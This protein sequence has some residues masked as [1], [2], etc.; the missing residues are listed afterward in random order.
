MKTKEMTYVALFAAI[1]IVLGFLPPIVLPFTPVPITAQTL[2]VMLAGVVLGARL[3]G[4]SMIVF[5]LII[6][7][8]VP[9]LAGG[10]GG[11]SAFVGPSAGYILSWP[12]S[13]FLIGLLIEKAKQPL[14]VWKV[15]L[16]NFVAGIVFVYICGIPVVAFVMDIKLE[17]AA[18]SGLAYLPGDLLK[19][20][21]A[22]ALG[23]KIRQR[24]F[25]NQTALTENRTISQ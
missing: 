12:V 15:F 23:V 17:A 16:Y 8:G 11:V 9:G 18:V 22:A 10:R 20:I 5:L 6:L 2:G 3:G 14:K 7:A 1:M 13:A 4:M 21:I 25:K 24:L 19:A